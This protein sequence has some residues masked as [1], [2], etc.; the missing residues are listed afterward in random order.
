SRELG[1]ELEA[2][3]QSVVLIPAERLS[4]GLLAATLRSAPSP[5]RSIVYLGSLSGPTLAE[6][7]ADGFERAQHLTCDILIETLRTLQESSVP[8]PRRI[9]LV[10][11]GVQPVGKGVEPLAVAQAPLWGLGRAL[12]REH[13][14]LGWRLVD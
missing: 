7:A 2:S 14:E 6:A 8:P 11:R 12:M 10:T 9:W 3:G 4:A 5:F 13:P 1:A